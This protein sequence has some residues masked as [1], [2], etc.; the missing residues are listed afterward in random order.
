VLFMLVAALVVLTAVLAHILKSRFPAVW[1]AEG[2]PEKWLWLQ[3]ASPSDHIFGFLDERRYLA[4]G[5]VNYSRL[6]GAVRLG[7]YTLL[8]SFL[9]VAVCGAFTAIVRGW[10]AA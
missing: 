10:H 5:S 9:V 1:L 8:I 3:P 7:W 6:C 4:T 2:E